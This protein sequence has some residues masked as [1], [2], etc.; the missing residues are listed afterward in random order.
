MA[1][2]QM[3]MILRTY[4]KKIDD[5]AALAEAYVFI[6][7]DYPAHVIIEAMKKHIKQS[8]QLATPA[9]IIAILNPPEPELSPAVYF[10]IKKKAENGFGLLDSELEYIRKFERSNIDAVRDHQRKQARLELIEAN[11]WDK[12]QIQEFL[13][14]E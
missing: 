7:G 12:S 9:D 1:I 6:L 3:A 4:G 13:E 2:E 5:I 10:N 11:G 14:E 8:N